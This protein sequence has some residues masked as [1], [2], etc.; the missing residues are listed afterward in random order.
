MLKFGRYVYTV[1]T[2]QAIAARDTF[3]YTKQGRTRSGPAPVPKTDHR[4]NTEQDQR[5]RFGDNGRRGGESCRGCVTTCG[6]LDLVGKT[7]GERF[8]S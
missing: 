2:R 6:Q 5:G 1:H 4:A 7:E 8:V 3:D